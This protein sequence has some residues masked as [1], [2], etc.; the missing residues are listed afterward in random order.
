MSGIEVKY[1]QYT[2][3]QVFLLLNQQDLNLQWVLN[4]SG[5]GDGEADG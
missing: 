3:I 1:L 4:M 5:T 2:Y